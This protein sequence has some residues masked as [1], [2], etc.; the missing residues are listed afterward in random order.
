[1]RN[2]SYENSDYNLSSNEITEFFNFPFE[3]FE[4]VFHLISSNSGIL[5]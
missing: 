2:D 5:E 3:I 4:K 1:M